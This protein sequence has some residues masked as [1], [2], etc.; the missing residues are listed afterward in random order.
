MGEFSRDPRSP[1]PVKRRLTKVALM[2]T[3]SILGGAVKR[4][5]DPRFIRGEGGYLP[6]RHVDGE[7]H[8]VPVRSPVASGRIVSIDVAEAL[9][10]PGVVGVY[11]AADLPSNPEPPPMPGLPTET[12]RPSIASG[13]VRFAGEIVAVVVA[14]SA[15]QA[16]DAA[17]LVWA[18][19]EPLTALVDVHEAMKDGAPLLF[20]ELGTNIVFRDHPVSNPD[21]LD[22]ADVVVKGVF[23]NQRVAPVPM[24]PNSAMAYPTPGGL[25]LWVGSQDVFS[26]RRSV[27]RALGMLPEDVRTRVPDMGGGFG[28]KIRTYPEQILVAALATKLGRPVRWDETRRDNLATMYQGRDQWQQMEIG[29]KRD[30]KIVGLKVT[31]H[32]DSGAYCAYGPWLPILTL[33]MACGAYDIPKVDL[34]FISVVTNTTPTDAYRGAGRPEAAALIE[35][36]MDLLADEL[37]IDPVE[38]RRR[39]FIGSDAFPFETPAE[40]IYDSGDYRTALDT[41]CRMARY[42]ELRTEQQR[43]RES[44]SSHQLGIGVSSYVEVTSYAGDEEWASVEINEEGL[45]TLKVG[46]SSH[47][48]GHETAYTQLISELLKIPFESI[49]VLQGDT[50]IVAR[51]GGTGG[52]R[53]LQLGGSS[54]FRAGISVLGK[55]NKV[56]A[57]HYEAS[58]EDI[59]LSDDG[60]LGVAGVPDT[61]LSWGEAALLTVPLLSDVGT[62]ETRLFAEDIFDLAESTVPFGTHIS[63]VEVDIETGSTRVLRHIAVDDCGKILNPILVNGQIHGGVAQGYGQALAE[64][65]VHDAEGNLLS[66]NLV[67]YLIPTAETLPSFELAHTETPTP[68]NPLGVKGIGEAG[69][70]GSTPAVQNAVIDAV[71]H[72]GVR[73]IDMPA[74]PAR[75]WKAINDASGSA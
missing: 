55:A 8:M 14:E 5:E 20:P 6:N 38:L 22:G 72:L 13:V 62:V 34:E 58:V 18:D 17:E 60:I 73:H 50:G 52:S 25:E 28:A 10:S 69:A 54:L 43:R 42:D 27:S 29:A 23:R 74:T 41:A 24:E 65:V 71:S 47:G 26:H 12:A 57:D 63:V 67:S 32:Q 53:S 4:I 2:R 33:K 31:V 49:R 11:T 1:S 16:V 9:G 46:T 15:A 56:V 68:L 66:G 36:A 61:G 7:L 51:G 45:A 35:R 70:I 40:A 75:V 44:G 3:S 19:I 64:E 21:V 30:G 39:N 48:Q 37:S 59:V